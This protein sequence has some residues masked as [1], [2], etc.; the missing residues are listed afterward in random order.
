VGS[1]CGGGSSLP[2]A[3][4]LPDL[5]FG[6]G[7]LPVT[8]PVGFPLPDG[9]SIGSTM[10]DGSRVRTEVVMILPLDSPEVV[11][12]FETALVEAGYEIADEQVESS[13]AFFDFNGHGI[14]G[15]LTVR[16]VGSG[17]TEGFLV[18]VYI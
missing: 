13:S 17:L 4:E 18:F 6:Q 12:F 8:V 11:Q 5:E 7:E 9:T 1:A 16:S 15:T 3:N 10:I 14:D 2:P